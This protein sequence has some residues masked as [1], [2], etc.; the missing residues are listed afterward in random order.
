M[1]YRIDASITEALVNFSTPTNCT[2]LR[3]F[4][5]LVN[6]LSFSTDTVAKLLLP[7][8]PLLSTKHK[9]V[10]LAEHV[11]V[12]TRVKEHLIDIPTL[13]YFNMIKP[14]RLSTDASRQGVGF[15][16]Q[17]QSDTG[18]WTLAQAGS[19]FL[20]LQN[21]GM[22]SLNWRSWRLCGQ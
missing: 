2:D 1:L 10:W 3:S 19:R 9:F 16:F 21:Q 7:L 13:T 22:W 18:Q 8:P 11:Q 14:T 6:Q 17:Q 15:V 4:F 5:G 20:T 12:F